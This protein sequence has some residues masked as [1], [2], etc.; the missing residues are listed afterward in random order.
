LETVQDVLFNASKAL[1][2]KFDP[3][4]I[5]TFENEINVVFFYNDSGIYLFDGNVNRLITSISSYATIEVYKELIKAGIELDFSF[6]GQFVEF[7]IDY[8]VLN[9]L[10]WR[11]MDCRRN[12]VTLLYKCINID[13]VLDGN[14]TVEKVKVHD[15]IKYI[16]GEYGKDKIDNLNHLLTGS[17]IKKYVFYKISNKQMK[18]KANQKTNVETETTD[19]DKDVVARRSVGVEHF[20]L[21]DNFK[22]NM[23]KYI[24]N[25]IY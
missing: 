11:Q 2:K 15:M 25:K 14:N 18:K 17:I 7:D 12:T 21:S 9:Y 16:N 8:E 10:I 13:S 24:V 4:L 22:S 3:N 23:Q 19:V 20:F 6:S 5:Y 1:Y